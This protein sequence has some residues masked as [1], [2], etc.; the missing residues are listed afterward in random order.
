MSH[1]E[2]NLSSCP[3]FHLMTDRQQNLLCQCL[4]QVHFSA[5]SSIIQ[6]GEQDHQLWIVGQGECE[7]VKS[8]G[9]TSHLLATIGPGSLFGEMSFFNDKAHSATVRSRTDVSLWQL[10]RNCFEEL[11]TRDP[12]AAHQLLINLLNLTSER[13]RRMDDW[14]CELVNKPDVLDR[15]EEWAE[16]RTKLYNGWSF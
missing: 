5:N 11:Q 14:T 15:H 9:E 3:L 10:S 13:L 6:E 2:Y 4:K 8:V 12:L 16:F 1:C 7:V